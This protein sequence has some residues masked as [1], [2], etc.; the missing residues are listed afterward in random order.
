M[1][2][3]LKEF[4]SKDR[5]M[6]TLSDSQGNLAV[7]AKEH[8]SACEK[9]DKLGKKG[10]KA[11]PNKVAKVA[12]EV[13]QVKAQWNIGARTTFE[14]LQLVDES[15]LNLL[16]DVL[17]QFQTHELDQVE[18][19]RT[20]AEDC[21]NTLLNVESADEIGAFVARV[22]SGRAKTETQSSRTTT[23]GILSTPVPTT[24]FDDARSHRSA[25]SA[26]PVRGDAGQTHR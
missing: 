10:A 1:E 4:L 11:A 17:T 23:S 14:V 15:R 3:P 5:D 16:R 20:T 25:V 2:R 12:D 19:K 22:V 24:P 21:L 6:Q 7:L 8:D 13:E 18:R 26:G 9:A